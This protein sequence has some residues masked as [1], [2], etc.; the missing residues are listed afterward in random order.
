LNLV[1]T[2]LFT[3]LGKIGCVRA[4]ASDHQLRGHGILQG[5]DRRGVPGEAGRGLD[6][7]SAEPAELAAIEFGIGVADERL[8]RHGAARDGE[9]A[10]V[11][12]GGVEEI[13]GGK[14]PARARHMLDH[15]ARTAGKIAAHMMSKRLRIEARTAAGTIAHDHGQLPPAVEIGDLVRRGTGARRNQAG[16]A[17]GNRRRQSA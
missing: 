1:P 3:A 13:V 7:R 16:E 5:F 14:Q 4:G 12:R 15:Q 8:D 10:P 9:H 6:I 17:G 2:N 11:A